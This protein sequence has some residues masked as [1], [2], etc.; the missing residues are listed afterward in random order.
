MKHKKFWSV[1]VEITTAVLV[2]GSVFLVFWWNCLPKF[3]KLWNWS[4]KM[5]FLE[6]S[7]W[8]S[9]GLFALAVAGIVMAVGSR[10][11]GLAQWQRQALVLS[12]LFALATS[13]YYGI[14]SA[15]WLGIA[16][17]KGQE[18]SRYT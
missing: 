5:P 17:A 7:L 6:V 11:K 1:F 8:V 2:F 3:P 16:E 4:L 18:F 12:I 13:I 14:G 10:G 9:A 15:F